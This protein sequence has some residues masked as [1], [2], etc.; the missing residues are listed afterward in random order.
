[1]VRNIPFEFFTHIL[2]QNPQLCKLK[3]LISLLGIHHYAGPV[4]YQIKRFL[5][6]NKDVQQDMFFDSLEVSTNPFSRE[7][8]KY[9]VYICP[10]VFVSECNPLLNL[11]IASGSLAHLLGIS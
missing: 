2:V 11:I 4:V 10:F 6:K 9:R 3:P 7:I 8:T 1:M 5:E